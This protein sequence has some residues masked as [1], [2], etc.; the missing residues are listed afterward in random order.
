VSL[1]SRSLRAD[2]LG[3]AD[4]PVG[5]VV[6]RRVASADADAFECSLRALIEAASR[7]PERLSAD[8]LR[9]PAGPG[10]IDYH[11]LYRFADE[12]RL[13]DWERSPERQTLL[14]QLEP[15]SRERGRRE[16]TWLEAWFDL[17]EQAAPPARSRM[18]GLTWLAIWPLVSMALW[19]LAPWL[20]GL[21][22]LARTA[23]I[24]ALLV[25]A[26]TYIVMPPLTHLVRP[27]LQPTGGSLAPDLAA[28]E[29]PA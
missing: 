23:A 6:T 20:H 21:P 24:T 28:G 25:L 16:L 10:A 26:M 11:I 22:F 17:P 19:L 9:S 15:L 14:A 27:W 4:I 1:A 8:V 12:A 29:E 13:R 3:P 2:R 5:I 7:R 18:A